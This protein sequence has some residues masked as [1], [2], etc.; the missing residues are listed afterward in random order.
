MDQGILLT[1]GLAVGLSLCGI[2]SWDLLGDDLVEGLELLGTH[3]ASDV[4]AN[5]A[6]LVKVVLD[7]AV[8]DHPGVP[9]GA[10]A[11]DVV[12]GDDL[13]GDALGDVLQGQLNGAGGDDDGY[14]AGFVLEDD[15]LVG[16]GGGCH[17]GLAEDGHTHIA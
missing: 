11:G 12:G 8:T 17:C 3:G 5:V 4:V 7:A 13:V 15:A 14:A 1:D 16:H 6:A 9:E 2:K 10:V